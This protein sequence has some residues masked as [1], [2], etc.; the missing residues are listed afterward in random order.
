M[1]AIMKEEGDSVEEY[2]NIFGCILEIEAEYPGGAAAWQRFLNSNLR[3]PEDSSGNGISGTAVVKFAIDEEGNVTDVEAV[4]GSKV[5][6]AEAVRVIK[7][8]GKW[9]PGRRN[10][11]HIKSYKTQPVIF[12]W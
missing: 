6:S 7:K 9:T 1:P 3:F 12:R 8:S 10:G 11:R 4:S 5:L 2:D